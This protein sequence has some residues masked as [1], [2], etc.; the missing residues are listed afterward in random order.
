[1]DSVD[2]TLKPVAPDVKA[3]KQTPPFS[4]SKVVTDFNAYKKDFELTVI[5][6]HDKIAAI[7]GE[8]EA[9]LAQSA[10]MNA[11][12]E[13]APEQ[14]DTLF[15]NAKF[16]VDERRARKPD[17][18]Q[19]KL[20]SDFAAQLAALQAAKQ[21]RAASA[22]S[23]AKRAALAEKIKE[24][25]KA[26]RT[27]QRALEDLRD[28][29]ELEPGSAADQKK[30]AEVAASRTA[31]AELEREDAALADAITG[32]APQSGAA[33][34][35]ARKLDETYSYE[36]LDD[37]VL[38]AKEI[39]ASGECVL[40]VTQKPDDADLGLQLALIG[41]LA[42]PNLVPVAAAFVDG[43][44]LYVHTPYYAKG[45]LATW[46][47]SKPD[48]AAVQRAAFGVLSGVAYIHSRGA[49]HG[50]LRPTAVLID[51]DASNASGVRALLNSYWNAA[52]DLSSDQFAAPELAGGAAPT[53]AS[54]VFSFGALL[55]LLAGAPLERKS[56]KDKVATPKVKDKELAALLPQLLEHEPAKRIT[57]LHALS[58][59][60]FAPQYTTLDA[61]KDSNKTLRGVRAALQK[62][63]SKS[64]MSSEEIEKTLALVGDAKLF[65]VPQRLALP[66]PPP[67]L[68]AAAHAKE[69]LEAAAEGKDDD[70]D[71]NN[72]D[73]ADAKKKSGS[74]K[75]ADAKAGGGDTLEQH[76]AIGK[77]LLHAMLMQKPIV[78]K[79][80]P[81]LLKYLLG[82]LP[83][84]VRD[85]LRDLDLFDAVRARHYRQI[86]LADDA[87][88][89]GLS[90]ANG[91]AVTNTNREAYLKEAISHDL[92]DCRK[93][94]LDALR[95]GF[96]S[97][98]GVKDEVRKLKASEL[99]ILLAGEDYLSGELVLTRVNQNP[100][101]AAFG[102][103][104]RQLAADDLRRV[105]YAATG[106]PALPKVSLN[107][108]V[109]CVCAC[110]TLV[111]P[112]PLISAFVSLNLR[113]FV[114]T[115]MP[116]MATRSGLTCATFRSLLL[117]LSLL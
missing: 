87:S 7:I 98:S 105:L 110:T 62:L 30:E 76:E 28:D 113:S 71:D 34:L 47:K 12:V 10:R 4:I 26:L 72:A 23:V 88:A 115:P 32:H 40:K 91:A 18:E 69:K 22:A 94:A 49:H 9:T 38:K 74:K 116:A 53:P 45:N 77:A 39:G 1:L 58:H 52:T 24:A 5:P 13:A 59:A 55:A 57:A 50:A 73:D 2:A 92:I 106:V 95:K 17:P 104:L 44:H 86:R 19:A 80:A 101:N 84:S 114:S 99:A 67:P 51:D 3:P 96:F 46:L 37:G 43:P 83:S 89:L 117:I 90:M 100:A 111:S 61:L 79:V 15:G 81:V 107:V 66:T 70:D 31:L 78:L 63:G 93:P 14:F 82:V 35:A 54:D 8:L 16:F 6:A 112:R 11:V 103:T 68:D 21:H 102:A 64:L 85:L 48:E 20:C 97:I 25:K 42:H 41:K 65:V 109:V 108:V 29:G 36:A 60:Y 33:A 75:P 27:Q 56:L